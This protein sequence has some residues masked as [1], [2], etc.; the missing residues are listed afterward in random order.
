MGGMGGVYLAKATGAGGA[1]K[2]VAIKLLHE[3]LAGDEAVVKM[4]LDEA[5]IASALSHVNVCTTFDFGEV[6]G[7]YFLVMEYLE[8]EPLDRVLKQLEAGT[9]RHPLHP[10]LV[11]RLLA[12]AAEGLHAAHQLVG[13]DGKPLNVVH[14]DVSP[15]NIFVTYDGVTKVVDFGI[16]RAR[17]RSSSTEA[18]AFKGKFE[19]AAPEQISGGG[20]DRRADTWALGVCLW[21]LLT[22]KRLFQ[23]EDYSLTARAVIRDPIPKASTVHEDVPPEFDAIIEQALERNPD[24]RFQTARE[25][26]KAL[27]AALA[28]SGTAIDGPTIEEWLEELFPG[29][30]GKRQQLSASV[31]SSGPEALLETVPAELKIAN[32]STGSKR[33]YKSQSG[34]SGSQSGRSAAKL[35]P[36]NEVET[37]PSQQSVP[38]RPTPEVDQ[39]E[40]ATDVAPPP[41]SGGSSKGL[42]FALLALL[43]IAGGGAAFVF[44][45][46]AAEPEPAE[47][48][49][50]VVKEPTPAPKP[51]SPPEVATTVDAGSPLAEA[52]V[53]AGA[54]VAVAAPPAIDAGAPAVI[55]A[56]PVKAPKETKQP[57]QP[58]P[59]TPPTPV[60]P[61]PKPRPEPIAAAPV[62]G[63]PG[64]GQVR[65]KTPGGV[66]DVY[67]DGAKVGVTPLI[68]PLP[69]G[70]HS[71]E[72]KVDG[73]EFGGP[74]S[75][76]IAPG[77][78][79][80]IEVDLR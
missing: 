69:A 79:L 38:K 19:Y 51:P 24:A 16:A 42:V 71:F 45:R 18:G 39:Q 37:R 23:R 55:A 63:V 26:G 75:I 72:F 3:H 12:D 56:A 10:W 22:G 36:V 1:D 59:V 58:A 70:K 77:S 7:T 41:E 17:E 48:P 27:R 80:N 54:Q 35:A 5:R 4:F 9:D 25:F 50:V 20:V 11:A 31:R 44:G 33:N 6:E 76:T 60:D 43:L 47:E 34:R 78:D 2:V 61:P 46:P 40:Q 52:P 8:G 28:D 21:E 30:R 66:A 74:K 29:D 53:D 49:P 62:K 15:H 67:V 65:F 68:L 57:K 73:Y 32:T 13:A 64:G 14:R